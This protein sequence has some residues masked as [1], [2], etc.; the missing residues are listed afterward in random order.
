[1]ITLFSES[2][3]KGP[4]PEDYDASRRTA[5][6]TEGASKRYGPGE[7]RRRHDGD[8]DATYAR[9][10]RKEGKPEDAWLEAECGCGTVAVEGKNA[11]FFLR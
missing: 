5:A 6:N 4:T 8:G 1:M 11:V 3:N 10:S 7:L 9:A 2:D